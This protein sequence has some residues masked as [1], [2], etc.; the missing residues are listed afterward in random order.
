MINLTHSLPISL[1]QCLQSILIGL[2]DPHQLLVLL[3]DLIHS[4]RNLCN[5]AGHRITGFSLTLKCHDEVIFLFSEG[6]H[7][8]LVNCTWGFVHELLIFVDDDRSL[9]FPGA[10]F[11]SFEGSEV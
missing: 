7:D 6:L 8:C 10:A 2:S 5:L 3:L 4:H 1:I 9:L 11:S